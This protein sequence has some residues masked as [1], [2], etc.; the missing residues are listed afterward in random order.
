MASTNDCITNRYFCTENGTGIAPVYI[1]ANALVVS[2]LVWLSPENLVQCSILTGTLPFLLTCYVFIYYKIYRPEVRRPFEVPG[3]VRGAVLVSLPVVL[4][5][6]YY[7]YAAFADDTAIFGIPYGKLVFFS[8][9][10]V[11]GALVEVGISAH[12]RCTS[13]RNAKQ[14]QDSVND[15]PQKFGREQTPL[16][17][18]G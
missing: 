17:G 2:V 3:G 18:S 5:L 4:F 10:C 11:A 13:N 16:L 14:T 9:V 6:V 7:L 8:V 12:N 15:Y 1:I